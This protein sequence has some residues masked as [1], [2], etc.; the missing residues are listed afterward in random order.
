MKKMLNILL[1]LCFF[2]V[3]LINNQSNFVSSKSLSNNTNTITKGYWSEKNAPEF[4][5]TTKIIIKKGDRFT[6]KDPR[7]RIFARDFEDLDLTQKI[8]A[9]HNVNTEVAGEYE[10]NYTVTDSHRNK[11]TLKVP[12]IVSDDPNVK[13]M[14]ERT[15][16]TLPSVDNIKAMGIE[17]GHNNDRQMLGIFVKSGSNVRIRKTAGDSNL[18]Y[19]MLNNDRLTESSKTI[20]DQWQTITFNHDYTPFIKT[21]YKHN[22]PVKVEIEWDSDD[23]GVKK[24]N[25]Y[26]EGDDEARFFKKWKEDPNTYSVVESNILT[27]LV[28]YTDINEI[29]GYYKKGF[30]SLDAFF[31]YYR[32]VVETY[33]KAIGLSYAPEN[34]YDQNVNTRFFIKANAHGVGAAYYAT[35][36]IGVNKPKV[37]SFFEANWGGLHEI[38]HGYQ[39]SLGKGDLQIGEVS[40]NIL[41]HYV[42]INR[43]I[44]PY[45]ADWLGK[46][47]NIEEKY[48]KVRLD[49][50]KFLDLSIPGR[51]Y[52]V[53]N[54][55]D[56]FEGLNT[57]AHIAKLYRKN[58][59]EGKELL[60]QDAWALGIFDKYGVSLVDY[61][62]AWGIEVSEE[63]RIEIEQKNPNNAFSLK[64][65]AQSQELINNIK[66]DLN[67]KCNY[68]LVTNEQLKKYNIKGSSKINIQIEDI[69]KLKGKY[70]QIKEGNKEIAKAEIDANEVIIPNI[71][72]GIYELSVPELTGDY[73]NNSKNILISKDKETQFNLVYKIVE[74]NFENDVKVQFQGRYFS[75]AAEIKLANENN[76]LKL[77]FRYRGTS[78]FNSG[79]K[80]EVEYAKIQVLDSNNTNVYEKIVRGAGEMFSNKNVETFEVPVNI[81]YKLVLKYANSNNKLKFISSL[82]ND[83]RSIYEIPRDIERI[84]VVTEEG[85]KP[86]ALS[87]QEYY[88]EYIER[89]K[90][91]IDNFVR[92]VSEDKIVN[93][94]Y[95][96]DIKAIIVNGYRK[97]NEADKKAYEQLYNKIVN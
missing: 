14:I 36:H 27:V 66:S 94:S 28:P 83:Y 11:T 86:E 87:E 8:R 90:T 30:K 89:M 71:P 75:D 51:L 43:S 40:N 15:M 39:G 44:F 38:G 34:P 61:F 42:Q 16:Y 20:T 95:Y 5:G 25:Y 41:A 65:L 72:V 91:Y 22:G 4:Y 78:L 80:P 46:L 31:E 79:V 24:L 92:D 63:T 74:N 35:D 81:G 69:N 55:L 13:P 17:R 59:I 29:S 33:D 84:F 19:T 9:R 18:L 12:V 77:N 26:H 49:G 32:K 23:T 64:D 56:S 70:I 73:T 52:F 54:F 7:Y 76:N 60:T 97:M 48:N 82:N 67:L 57:Y 53:I 2:T 85:L 6:V 58:I 88:N 1:A 93:K 47:P 96:K 62:D 10:I 3:L 37:S 50:G 45:D 68:Q 21:L